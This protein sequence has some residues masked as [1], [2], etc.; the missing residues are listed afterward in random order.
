MDEP[1]IHTTKGNLHVS[2]LN[3]ET[4]WEFEESYVKFIETYTLN[5]EVVRQS[6]HVLSMQGVFAEATAQSLN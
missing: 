1:L 6:V 2:S 5:G 3:Y 4:T